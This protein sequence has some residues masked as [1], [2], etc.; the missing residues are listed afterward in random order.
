MSNAFCTDIRVEVPESV[1]PASVF[2]HKED[3]DSPE[4]GHPTGLFVFAGALMIA[5]VVWSM[6]TL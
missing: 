1:V 6:K 4:M 3:E 5:E 2:E